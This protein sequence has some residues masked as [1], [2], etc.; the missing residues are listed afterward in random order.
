MEAGVLYVKAEIIRKA[1]REHRSPFID[2][3]KPP[4]QITHEKSEM[5]ILPPPKATELVFK[6]LLVVETFALGFSDH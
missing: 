6:K 2:T 5:P 4:N 1:K 3:V